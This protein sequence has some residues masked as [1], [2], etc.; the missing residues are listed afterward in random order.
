[1]V[2]PALAFRL[3]SPYYRLVFSPEKLVQEMVRKGN[4]RYTAGSGADAVSTRSLDDREDHIEHRLNKAAL[5]FLLSN[6]P[7]PVNITP[8]RL[9]P[10]FT[11]QS[12]TFVKI[13]QS[14][15]DD[16][17]LSVEFFLI[18]VEDEP[19]ARDAILT[20]KGVAST[21]DK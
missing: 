4:Q 7:K 19:V 6:W 20:R 12:R 9:G 11:L 3:F 21:L 10:E 13:I 2:T 5:S 18:G 15:I 16:G 14:L 1:M 17:L 8:T